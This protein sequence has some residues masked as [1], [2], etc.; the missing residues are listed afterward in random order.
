MHVVKKNAHLLVSLLH[1][2][3]CEN[4]FNLQK[5]SSERC[6]Y[7]R[8][9]KKSHKKIIKSPL[10]LICTSQR[11]IDL[12][13]IG[14]YHRYVISYKYME[15]ILYMLP[16][17]LGARYINEWID[18]SIE[19]ISIVFGSWCFTGHGWDV[20]SVDW[21]PQKSLLVSGNQ[22]VQCLCN[23]RFEDAIYSGCLLAQVQRTI[24][25]NCGMLRLVVNFVHCEL[26]VLNVIKLPTY[27]AFNS[28]VSYSFW[29]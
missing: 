5:T 26:F 3:V 15:A 12:N 16:L 25:W 28:S 27:K 29:C 17:F 20:K 4:G 14:T 24:L 2:S 18:S 22:K 6:T 8:V 1:F 21:H 23:V 11:Y 7:S 13:L 19:Y 10:K 9:N